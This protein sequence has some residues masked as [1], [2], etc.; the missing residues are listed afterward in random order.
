MKLITAFAILFP[1]LVGLALM[2]LRPQDGKLRNRIAITAA[3]IT[4]LMILSVVFTSL[5]QGSDAVAVV[6]MKF[7]DSLRLELR[8]DGASAVFACIISILWP[9]TVVYAFSYMSHETN[10]NRF[11]GFFLIS[12]GTVAGIVLAGNFLT[13]YFFYELMTL[14]T[15]PLVMH[16]MNGKARSAGTKYIAYSMVGATLIFIVLVFFI[17]YG[18]TLDFVPGGVLDLSAVAGYEGVLRFVFVLGFIG[19]GVKAG[20]FPLNDWLPSASVA[21]TPV[22]AL[23]HAVAV[24]KSGAFGV[25]RLIYFGFGTSF[26]YGSAAQAVVICLAALTVAYGSVMALRTGH[27]KRR[28]AYSTIANLSYILL[29]F[30]I[31]TSGGF[32]GGMLHMIYH[33]VIKI[34]LFFCAGSIL[35]HSH[36]EYIDDM[37]GLGRRMPVTCAT[38][39]FMSFALCGIPP[40]GAFISKWTIGTAA[41]GLGSWY[42]IVGAASLIVSA[43]LSMLYMMTVLV[44]FY[45]PLKDAAPLPERCHEADRCMTVPLVALCV[46][47][48]VLSCCSAG[49]IRWLTALAVG[50]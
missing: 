36:L 47:C 45:L 4:A 16:E 28:L 43:I 30:A 25:M 5:R 22:T 39:A 33:A 17:H 26:L 31:M 41:A 7:S 40:L 14:S 49:L 13:L 3:V 2:T 35:H 42:G 12:F 15:L 9:T 29:G 1:I 23:L 21:P 32:T 37:E 46:L 50:M 34:S 48:V 38:F 44:R 10:L 6:L 20:L 18:K 8:P 24:V 27:L 19:F 11:Y